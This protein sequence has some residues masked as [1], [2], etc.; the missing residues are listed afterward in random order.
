MWLESYR[1]GSQS[2]EYRR[3]WT[4]GTG[5]TSPAC[6][7]SASSVLS[8]SWG[9][10]VLVEASGLSIC[11]TDGPNEENPKS[12]LE[13]SPFTCCCTVL[14]SCIGFLGSYSVG[15]GAVS[16]CHRLLRYE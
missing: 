7:P 11:P 4:V 2:T 13:A 1:L 8:V 9:S 12:L 14:D 10:I 3:C 15:W 5:L 16:L 6:M